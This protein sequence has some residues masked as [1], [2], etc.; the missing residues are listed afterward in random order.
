MAPLASRQLE[1]S[2]PGF[3]RGVFTN[4][5]EFHTDSVAIVIKTP[6]VLRINTVT[7]NDRRVEFTYD[8]STLTIQCPYS[9]LLLA[10]PATIHVAFVD[11][12][13]D[14]CHAIGLFPAPEPL[15]DIWEFSRIIH[16][17][18]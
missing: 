16:L 15:A 14:D 18:D 12:N 5:S 4:M 1:R 11:A 17:P 2:A 8:R 7:I 6:Q 3:E 13:E 9:V 10:M